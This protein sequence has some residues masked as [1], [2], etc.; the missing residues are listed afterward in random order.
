M[1]NPLRMAA[2]P[3]GPFARLATLLGDIKPD[4]E[5]ISL[6]VGD[7]HG[8]VP[9]F[10]KKA[11]AE[12]AAS[13]G[14]YPAII[15]TQDWRQAAAAWLNRRFRLNG[16]IDAEKN[17]L[18][19]DGTREGL[20]TVLFPFMP[21]SKK[22]ARP[23]VAMP[24]PFYQCYAA[25]ALASGA[26]P[27]YVPSRKENGF[28]PDFAGLPEATLER[29]AAIYICS[30]SNPE[31]A[32]ASRGYWEQ[33]FVLAERHDFLVLADECYADI[34][35]GEEPTGALTARQA[36]SGGFT[37]LLTFHSLSKRSGLPGL[38]SGMVAG[39]AM[40]IER[41][42][43]F[44]NVAGPT[45]PTP[46][47]AASA[48]CWRDEDH[49]I[50]NRAGYQEKMAAAERIL[51]NRMVRPE[52]GFFLWLD[53][54]NGEEFTV[55]AW[56]KQGVR[57]LPGAFMGRDV[58]DGRAGDGSVP[59]PAGRSGRQEKTQSNPGFSYVRVALVNDLS[60]IMTALERLRKIL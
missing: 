3:P 58:F 30:P 39:D 51:G 37:R 12:S 55:R 38:R 32:V 27:L 24:N 2:L 19:L 31:G 33:L 15:G 60:T 44:R 50:A 42:R 46:L 8:A 28:L 45:V 47:L 36:Q 59:S 14:N 53:V 17:L 6:A 57:L 25:A 35:F 41:F 54:G 49:V 20:F 13:F 10:V 18:P 56:R 34:Y 26:E 21:E 5:P 1:S 52:G 4:M 22:G 48:A 40:L 43:A 7:P 23:I 11:I 29:L 16:A 9:D